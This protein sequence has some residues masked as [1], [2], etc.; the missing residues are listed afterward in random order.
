MKELWVDIKRYVSIWCVALI[1][2]FILG[3]IITWDAIITDC[4]VLGMTRFGNVPM[5]CRVGEKYQ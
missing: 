1:I 4:K 5:G 3:K 2:G